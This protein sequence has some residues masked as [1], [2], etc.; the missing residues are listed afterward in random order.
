MNILSAVARSAAVEGADDSKSHYSVSRVNHQAGLLPYI[1]LL[2]KLVSNLTDPNVFYEPWMLMPA[3]DSFAKAEEISF[4]LVFVDDGGGDEAELAAFFPL[5]I[6]QRYRGLP[7]GNVSLWRHPHCFLTTPLVHPRYVQD[8]AMLL[9]NWF[10]S[11]KKV[12][13]FD[14]HEIS[15]ES[16]FSRALHAAIAQGHWVKR[17]QRY[18]RAAWLRSEGS[19]DQYLASIMSKKSRRE[20]RRLQRKLTEQGELSCNWVNGGAA[21]DDWVDE[22][23]RLEASGWKGRIGTAL[24]C[25]A[26]GETFFRRVLAQAAQRDRL[27]LLSMCVDNKAIAMI[28]V[29][30]AADGAYGFKMAFDERYRRYGPGVMLLVDYIRQLYAAPG[31]KWLDSCAKP[32]HDMA[33][34]LLI[35]RIAI[36]NILLAKPCSLGA[37]LLAL[38]SLRSWAKQQLA[39]L[40]LGMGFRHGV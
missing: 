38:L 28:A 25:S 18:A 12:Q 24:K 15:A 36:E 32:D 21:V 7:I 40:G 39:G 13:L 14:F 10:A 22:F 16:D 30:L 34:R 9:L 8:C 23:L 27:Q 37:L 29:L 20:Y 19:F 11:Q 17:C 4:L 35:N 5:V 2:E 33:N 6:R 3:L 1:G 31:L 26:E